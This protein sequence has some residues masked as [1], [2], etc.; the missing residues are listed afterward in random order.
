MNP[1]QE[2][3]RSAD[4]RFILNHDLYKEAWNA[5]ADA[6]TQ[7]R[8]KVALKDT[9]M[10]TRLIMAEQV[11]DSV[12]RHIEDAMNTGRMAEIQLKQS[13]NVRRWLKIG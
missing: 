13:G 5:T 7:Q 12:R 2:I 1:E 4:A 11:L 10:H 9:D 6:L 8:R 3:R